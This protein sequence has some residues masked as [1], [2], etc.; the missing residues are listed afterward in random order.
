MNEAKEHRKRDFGAGRLIKIHFV[1]RQPPPT[2]LP[3]PGPWVPLYYWQMPFA[4]LRC[5][6]KNLQP[7]SVLF[8]SS[9]D[10]EGAKWLVV[11]ATGGFSLDNFTMNNIRMT[12]QKRSRI[13]SGR[14]ISTEISMETVGSLMDPDFVVFVNGPRF[15]TNK[16]E[17]MPSKDE[18]VAPANRTELSSHGMVFSFLLFG[19]L[20]KTR[21]SS[22]SCWTH[23]N[24]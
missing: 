7:C 18:L 4:L 3:F 5:D 12:L 14:E 13:W 9:S 15:Y 6:N 2:Q 1:T 16:E 23:I 24:L 8:L 20:Y 11:P 10:Q 17:W 22:N 19:H 21:H